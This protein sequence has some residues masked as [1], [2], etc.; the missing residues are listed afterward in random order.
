[1]HGSMNINLK[2]N[3][4]MFSYGQLKILADG[5]IAQWVAMVPVACMTVEMVAS[6]A[7]FACV[8]GTV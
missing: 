4:Y 2:K 7:L 8:E 6:S 5:N 3:S 1:M